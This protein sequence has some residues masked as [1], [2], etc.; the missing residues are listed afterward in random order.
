MLYAQNFTIILKS[1]KMMSNMRF[2]R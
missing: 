1:A 2:V